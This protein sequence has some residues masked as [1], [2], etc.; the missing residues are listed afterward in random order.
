MTTI[1][2]L[3][4]EQIGNLLGAE[5]AADLLRALEHSEPSVSVR[6]NERRGAQ[7][8]AGADR[9]PWCPQGFYCVDRPAFTFDVDHHAGMYYVQDASSMFIAHVIRNLVDAPVR[10]LDLCAAP[11]GKTTAAVQALP[12]DSLVVANEYVA[13]RARV[14]ADNVMR[15]GSDNVVVT[16]AAPAALGRL[17]HHFDVVAAD[18]PCS[19]EGMMRKDDEAVAQWSPALV[20]QCAARQRSIL[21]DVWPALRPGGLM[22]Y[23]TCTFNLAENEQMVN[24]LIE[25]FGAEPVAVPIQ[26][27]WH[28]APAIDSSWRCSASP[29]SQR[30]AQQRRGA[31]T[32]LP[33]RPNC[34]SG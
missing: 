12:E 15:W 22:I 4:A 23:S 9:V 1:D 17:T 25:H 32:P 19:G 33:C 26:D 2:S 10:Y 20:E 7:V 6:V 21:D 31:T 24:Y 11:G 28:I 13:G 14:L 29:T 5:Q 30:R 34:A 8:P 27:E 3:F 16:N 18:V